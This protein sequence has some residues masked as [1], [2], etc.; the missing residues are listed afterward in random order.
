M[1]AP[2][3]ITS[4]L[5]SCI[6]PTK[7]RAAYIPQAIHSYQSQT[8]PTKELIILDNGTDE[9]ETLIPPDPSIS[10]TRISGDH[11]TGEMRNLC[12]RLAK[13]EVIAH[14]D[15]DDWSAPTRL[16]DQVHRLGPWGVLTGYNT[17]LFYDDRDKKCYFWKGISIPFALGTSLCYR[18]DWWMTHPFLPMQVGEDLKFFQ[19]AM[20]GAGRYVHTVP[21][22]QMM[23]ARVHDHQTSRK[24][25]TSERYC[26]IAYTE[27]PEAFFALQ[28]GMCDSI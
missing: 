16:V 2:S 1:V 6:L 15:S 28:E 3:S 9:T 14:F 7:N 4:P 5:I 20:R 26:P 22:G 12:A 8:Y 23:V 11:T 13:G 24:A 21:G 10:Y 17:L 19:E 18:K 27:L 25:L